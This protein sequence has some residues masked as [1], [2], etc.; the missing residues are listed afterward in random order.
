MGERING[1][2]R[3]HLTVAKMRRL[4]KAS[5]WLIAPTYAAWRSA[6]PMVSSPLEP[7]RRW[8]PKAMRWETLAVFAG[9]LTIGL[10][11]RFGV[12]I[13]PIVG[14]AWVIGG[15]YKLAARLLVPKRWV[16]TEMDFFMLTSLS[17]VTRIGLWVGFLAGLVVANWTV[18][19]V[20]GVAAALLSLVSAATMLAAQR[21]AAKRRTARGQP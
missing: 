17:T 4:G 8:N 19:L 1:W 12:P 2:E 20:L 21:M 18:A 7:F 13:L 15:T 5:L 14:V 10:A 11:L 9:G 16:E 3:P 6:R